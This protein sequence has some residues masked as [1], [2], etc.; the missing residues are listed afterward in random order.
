[1][2]KRLSKELNYSFIITKEK[3]KKL[4]VFFKQKL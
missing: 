3:I 1:M 4:Y 2:K